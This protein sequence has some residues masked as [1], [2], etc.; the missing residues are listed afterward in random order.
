MLDL[1]KSFVADTV[2]EC[3]EKCVDE[4]LDARTVYWHLAEGKQGR[5]PVDRAAAGKDA[6]EAVHELA[7]EVFATLRDRIVSNVQLK[8]R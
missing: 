5:L 3:Q 7:T 4:F 2:R 6:H 1:F 8:V